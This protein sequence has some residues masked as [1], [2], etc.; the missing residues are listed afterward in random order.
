[1]KLNF[2]CFLGIIIF[3]TLV[4]AAYSQPGAPFPIDTSTIWEVAPRDQH[5]PAIAFDGTNYLVTWEHAVT[6]GAPSAICGARMDQNGEIIDKVPI[7]ISD[8]GD[9]FNVMCYSNVAFDGTYYLIVW[10]HAVPDSSWLCGARVTTDGTVIDSPIVISTGSGKKDR[11]SIA[12]GNGY[13]LIVWADGRSGGNWDLMAVRMDTA[14]QVVGSEIIID[15]ATY[16]LWNSP[17]PRQVAFD[18]ENFL[19]VW[20]HTPSGAVGDI[21]GAR[22]DTAGNVLDTILICTYTD[23]QMQPCVAFNGTYH[24]VVWTDS[25]AGN[26]NSIYGARV[27]T[28]GTVLDPDGFQISTGIDFRYAPCVSAIGTG[29]WLVTWMDERNVQ[30]IYGARVQNNG[31]VLDPNG[32]RISWGEEEGYAFV[33]TDGQDCLVAWS[34]WRHDPNNSKGTFCEIYG[35]FLD[36]QGNVSPTSGILITVSPL[37]KN[38]STAAFDI[39]NNNY[40]VVWDNTYALPDIYGRRVSPSGTI[41]DTQA[42][43]L[44]FGSEREYSPAI[45]FSETEYF[46]VWNDSRNGLNTRVYGSR[47]TFQGVPLDSNGIL[48]GSGTGLYQRAIAYGDSSYLVAWTVGFGNY[49]LGALV[50][51]NGAIL[52]PDIPI[53]DTF[54]A[55]PELWFAHPSI[56]FDGNNYFVVWAGRDNTGDTDIKGARVRLDGTVIDKPP[57]TISSNSAL[58]CMPSVAYADNG[59]FL[60]TWT[61]ARN[62]GELRIYGAR[63]DTAGNVLDSAG[64][65]MSVNSADSICA[66]SVPP[67]ITF[68]GNHYVAGWLRWESGGFKPYGA[69]VSSQGTVI[70]T[71]PFSI[72]DANCNYYLSVVHGPDSQ[73]L[74]TYSIGRDTVFW[75]L[76]SSMDIWGT[77]FNDPPIGIVT[78]PLSETRRTFNL[79]QT[80]P[81]PFKQSTEIRYQLA[82]VDNAE[83]VSLKIYDATGRLVKTFSLPT[84]YSLLPTVIPW[85]GTDDFDRKL[86]AGIYFCRLQDGE[87]TET[88]KMILLR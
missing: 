87:L 69:R 62:S 42:I 21:W 40:L 67:C 51:L 31:N 16:Q 24:F 18:G 54:P 50:D 49:I 3:M 46:I 85:N 75:P 27:N 17:N 53:S 64:I 57:I 59:I 14:G 70:D 15:T 56:T 34:D 32:I 83:N 47:V 76:Y 22:I 29:R 30:D 1:M 5:R 84:A 79:S 41:L 58:Q 35:T 86:P 80:Y 88:Q 28:S 33:E 61:D 82:D 10:I 65:C 2:R 73:S 38:H 4:G 43:R 60:V 37:Q 63:V 36:P 7:I 12:F 44:T 20:C 13:Y 39:N 74:F 55:P 77:F 19:T 72:V 81:N 11:P 9:A 71:T 52:A 66:Y 26:T 48:I 6:T 8:F 68:G 23:I 78:E 45:A 25:R